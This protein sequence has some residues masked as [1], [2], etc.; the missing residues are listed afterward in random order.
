MN[1][2]FNYA[3]QN[4]Q[5]KTTDTQQ[6]PAFWILTF[7]YWEMMQLPLAMLE[8]LKLLTSKCTTLFFHLKNFLLNYVRCWR[9]K[10]TAFKGH[11]L[12]S[13][14]LCAIVR[15]FRSGVTRRDHQGVLD[16]TRWVSYRYSRHEPT[17]IWS[18]QDYLLRDWLD[19]CTLLLLYCVWTMK[20]RVYHSQV[21]FALLLMYQIGTF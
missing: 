21:Q 6:T 1:S 3:F 5:W 7:I 4:L 11:F 12:F 20:F 18:V 9:E 8:W 2:F 15:D 17:W 19:L 13:F 16:L 14:L 10:E